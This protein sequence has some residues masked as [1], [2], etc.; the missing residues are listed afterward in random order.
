MSDTSEKVISDIRKGKARSS[1]LLYGEEEFS[2]SRALDALVDALVPEQDRALNLVMLDGAE[3]AWE[4]VLGHLRTL[5]MFGGRKVVVVRDA[6]LGTHLK[7]VFRR[8]RILWQEG[9]EGNRRRAATI[10]MGIL[11][12]LD[13][14]LEALSDGGP[15]APEPEKWKKAAAID[16]EPDDPKWMNSLFEYTRAEGLNPRKAD[17]T[18]QI[19]GIIENID[20]SD[21]VLV[22]TSAT[23]NQN[24]SFYKKINVHGVIWGFDA[25]K[26][27]RLKRASLKSEI[28]GILAREGKK[29]SADAMLRL[30][31]KTGFDLRRA[32]VEI[33]K[34]V[35]FIGDRKNITSEDINALVPQTK[36][37]SVFQLTD[38]FAQRDAAEVLRLAHELMASDH[39]PLEILGVVH[40]LLRNLLL[41]AGYSRDISQ[42]KLW[43]DKMSYGEFQKQTWPALKKN[44]NGKKSGKKKTKEGRI[45][46]LESPPE[47]VFPDL[48]PFVAYKAMKDQ[49]NFTPAELIRGLKLLGAVDERIKRSAG[50]P[51]VLI[52]QTVLA[53]CKNT[54]VFLDERRF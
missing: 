10:M 32:A 7:D 8:A 27:D 28:D 12:D 18:A 5:P 50:D 52:E 9:S 53:I 30:E 54:P 35:T 46:E 47:P 44:I 42:Q 33:E 16:I 15:E 48:H 51:L 43:N 40:T 14:P 39:H 17:E 26:I 45:V 22:L 19:E 49:A 38:A 2:V 21:A 36:E 3:C 20:P 6:R 29:I 4:E 23:A 37:E 1:Y 11:G 31:K 13:W 25:P 34:L 24:S 41:A